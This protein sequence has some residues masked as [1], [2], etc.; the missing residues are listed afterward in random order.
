MKRGAWTT[1]LVGVF[2][3]VLL[4]CGGPPGPGG[5]L[6]RQYRRGE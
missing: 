2:I 6:V 4:G 3:L 5:N 1:S